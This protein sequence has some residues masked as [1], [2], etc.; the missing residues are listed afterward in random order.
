[1]THPRGYYWA[2]IRGMPYIRKMQESDCPLYLDG[3]GW[4]D[5]PKDCPRKGC[6]GLA[7]NDIESAPGV[8]TEET[9]AEQ[10]EILARPSKPLKGSAGG[11]AAAVPI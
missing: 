7:H 9:P 11:G 1:M 3:T 4:R 2:G 6:P 10:R 5:W 8:R